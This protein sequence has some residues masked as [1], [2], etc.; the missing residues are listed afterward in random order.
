MTRTPVHP[1][2][3]RPGVTL[4]SWMG[5]VNTYGCRSFIQIRIQLISGFCRRPHST[6]ALTELMF[7]GLRLSG[8]GLGLSDKWGHSYFFS[9]QHSLRRA[10]YGQEQL[11]R[12]TLAAQFL[13]ASPQITRFAL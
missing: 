3:T 4:A 1:P 12:D 9:W 6:P 11:L 10:K 8:I 5:T 2:A 13:R 7:A